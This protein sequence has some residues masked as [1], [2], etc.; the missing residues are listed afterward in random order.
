MLKY[1]LVLF[2]LLAYLISWGSRFFISAHGTGLI[3]HDIPLGV[4]QITAQFGPSIAGVIMIFA[5]G[6]K[7]GISTLFESLTRFHIRY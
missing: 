6:G 7:K 4:L 3:D 2:C 1:Q 5:A